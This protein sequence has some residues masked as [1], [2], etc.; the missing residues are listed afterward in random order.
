MTIFNLPSSMPVSF[1]LVF[2]PLC[3]CSHHYV[4]YTCVDRSICF[5]RALFLM[6]FRRGSSLLP[7]LLA[8]GR[9]QHSAPGTITSALWGFIDSTG[10][11]SSYD[12]WR[13]AALRSTFLFFTSPSAHPPKAIE[14]SGVIRTGLVATLHSKQPLSHQWKNWGRDIKS[15]GYCHLRVQGKTDCQV[16][17]V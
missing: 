10:N 2:S 17:L 1:S 3:Q 13:L 12:C 11:L 15:D 4:M 7:S 16:V 9:G 6:K 8:T 5:P 14:L